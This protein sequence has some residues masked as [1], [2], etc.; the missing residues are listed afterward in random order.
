MKIRGTAAHIAEKY[1]A[2]GR[3]LQALDVVAAENFFQHAEHY[4]RIL[5]AARKS[6]ESETGEAGEEGSATDPLGSAELGGKSAST[7]S[8]RRRVA[9]HSTAS[10]AGSVD[11]G[12]K[13]ADTGRRNSRTAR[14]KGTTSRRRS[15][16][17]AKT[18]SKTSDGVTV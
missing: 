6:V 16:T 4:N 2:H 1:T 14:T 15:P 3:D 9:S 18:T 13:S 12:Q 11:N 10:E 5:Q 8:R 17:R 7:K